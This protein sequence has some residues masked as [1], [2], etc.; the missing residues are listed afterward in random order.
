[1]DP[2]GLAGAELLTR[3]V[4][5]TEIAVDRNPRVPDFEGLVALVATSTWSSGLVNVVSM[6]K[7]LLQHQQSESLLPKQMRPWAEEKTQK[8]KME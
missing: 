1:M 4:Y 2:S 7:W 8:E 3:R 5:Q 6:A